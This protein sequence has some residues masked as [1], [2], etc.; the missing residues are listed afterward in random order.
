[1]EWIYS[2][3]PPCGSI[4]WTKRKEVP[5]LSILLHFE[6]RV[7]TILGWF[8]NMP[9]PVFDTSPVESSVSLSPHSYSQPMES[10]PSIVTCLSPADGSADSPAKVSA[11]S[12]Y[13]LPD[14]RG[15]T[16]PSDFGPQTS[17]ATPNCPSPPTWGLEPPNLSP[18][19]MEQ[20]SMKQHRTVV[21][22][23]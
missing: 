5:G 19:L 18:D 12:Q 1:M 22:C 10:G 20:S 3:I 13:Q 23:H 7:R 9:L 14:T 11:H 17:Q 2:A 6:S 8:Y 4:D 16:S 15:K 21:L